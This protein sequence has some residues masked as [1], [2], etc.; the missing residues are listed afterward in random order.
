MP[1]A[2]L[3]RWRLY[4]PLVRRPAPSRHE[5]TVRRRRRAAF[6]ATTAW[7]ARQDRYATVRARPFHGACARRPE[8][9]DKIEVS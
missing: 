2:I 3:R 6:A 8:A 4:A 9:R 7:R 5:R 1:C